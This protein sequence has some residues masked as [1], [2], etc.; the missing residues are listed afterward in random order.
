[1]LHV[2]LDIIDMLSAHVIEESEHFQFQYYTH[3]YGRTHFF[4]QTQY[5]ICCF[6]TLICF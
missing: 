6:L 4:A 5:E 3:P 2:Y 1:M